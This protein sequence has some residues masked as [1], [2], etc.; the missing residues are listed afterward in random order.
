MPIVMWNRID[1]GDDPAKML[2]KLLNEL[3]KDER[4]PLWMIE[5]CGE[6][7]QNEYEKQEVKYVRHKVC[8]RDDKVKETLIR[9]DR[10]TLNMKILACLRAILQEKIG[11][12]FAEGLREMFRTGKGTGK[13]KK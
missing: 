8:N 7:I 5:T 12:R 10:L 1:I 6:G 2:D 4:Y 9:M 13:P 3:N 11:V